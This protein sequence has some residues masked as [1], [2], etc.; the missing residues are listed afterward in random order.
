MAIIVVSDT[1]SLCGLGIV[2]YL[3]LLQ[4]IYGQVLIPSAV[5]DELIKGGKDDPR[6]AT[7]LSQDWIEVR[8]P[9]DLQ[10]VESL[11]RE[12]HLDRG[13]SE[14]ITLALELN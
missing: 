9:I 2:G 12:C 1:S 8:Q 3:G 6:I 11:Q 10:R 13:E 5:A 4:Q 14:A 7:D